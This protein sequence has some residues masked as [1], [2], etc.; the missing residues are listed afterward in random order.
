[1]LGSIDVSN[2]AISDVRN[3][4][5]V[6]LFGVASSTSLV[7]GVTAA[8]TASRSNA[9]ADVSGMVTAVPFISCVYTG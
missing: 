6:G 5:P 9:C 3:A 8:A 1:M 2:S 7:A 4:V